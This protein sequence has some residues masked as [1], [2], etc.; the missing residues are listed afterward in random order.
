MFFVIET[1]GGRCK[2]VKIEKGI[3]A[4]ATSS[5]DSV[6]KGV[7]QILKN[8]LCIAPPPR[9]SERPESTSI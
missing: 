4:W 5:S 2:C 1:K 3:G 7:P 8:Y 6:E 9:I